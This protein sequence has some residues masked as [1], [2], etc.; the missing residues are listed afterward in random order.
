TD[1]NAALSVAMTNYAQA[2]QAQVAP[3]TQ[4]A[5]MSATSL[6]QQTAQLS[7][8]LSNVNTSHAPVGGVTA[9]QSFS[10]T[11]KSID[12]TSFSLGSFT[13]GQSSSPTASTP[14]SSMSVSDQYSQAAFGTALGRLSSIK[15]NTQSQ[16]TAITKGVGYLTDT[17]LAQVA[18]METQIAAIDARTTAMVSPTIT[19][20][21]VAA[22]AEQKAVEIA[23]IAETVATQEELGQATMASNNV[24]SIQSRI[25]AFDSRISAAKADTTV[26]QT[27]VTNNSKLAAYDVEVA[28]GNVPAPTSNMTAPAS[29]A[30]ADIGI[31]LGLNP[32]TANAIAANVNSF[33]NAV[34]GV[35]PGLATVSAVTNYTETKALSKEVA[36]Q[37]QEVV[38]ALTAAGVANPYSFLSQDEKNQLSSANTLSSQAK[39]LGSQAIGIAMMDIMGISTIGMANSL[40]KSAAQSVVS[41][42]TTTASPVSKS[43]T[44]TDVVSNATPNNVSISYNTSTNTFTVSTP[45]S[46]AGRV[47]QGRFSTTGQA[48]TSSVGYRS[49]TTENPASQAVTANKSAATSPSTA[50]NTTATGRST[51]VG[52][53]SA[54][55]ENPASQ[56][57]AAADNV[58]ATPN[59]VTNTPAAGRTAV[60]AE[61]PA[62]KAVAASDNPATPRSLADNVSTPAS[63]VDNSAVPGVTRSNDSFL[64][65]TFTSRENPASRNIT[66]TV[67]A[68]AELTSAALSPTSITSKSIAGVADRVASAITRSADDIATTP[69]QST[70]SVT[71]RST[72]NVTPTNQVSVTP[73]SATKAPVATTPAV[74]LATLSGVPSASIPSSQTP[75]A[76]TETPT[77]QAV[78]TQAEATPPATTE[79]PTTATQGALAEAGIF[80]DNEASPATPTE[81]PSTPAATTPSSQAPTPPAD[82]PSSPTNAQP[83]A[84]N[85]TA[86]TSPSRDSVADTLSKIA[87]GVGSALGELLGV[88][89]AASK[90]TQTVN[91]ANLEN[92]PA[93]RDFVGVVPDSS[94]RFLEFSDNTTA[95][96]AL[97]RDL[98]NKISDLSDAGTT[99]TLNTII[100]KY[101]PASDS[102]NPTQHA[103]NIAR[104]VAND[105]PDFTANTPITVTDL[106]GPVGVGL[107]KGF[108]QAEEGINLPTAEAAKGVAAYTA[109]PSVPTTLK[110]GVYAP[111]NPANQAQLDAI[112]SNPSVATAEVSP[113]QATPAPQIV[114]DLTQIVRGAAELSPTVIAVRAAASFFDRALTP[115]AKQTTPAVQAPTNAVATPAVL[116]STPTTAVS[117][118]TPGTNVRQGLITSQVDANG[119]AIDTKGVDPRLVDIIAETAKDFPL[120]VELFSGKVG[121]SKGTHSRGLAVDIMIYDTAGNPLAAYMVSETANIYALFAERARKV[122]MK[123]YPELNNSFV[124]G[125]AFTGMVKSPGG[126]AKYGG[127][128]FMDFRIG[129]AINTNQMQAYKFGE[130]WQEGFEYYTAGDVLGIGPRAI[131]EADYAQLEGFQLSPAQVASQIEKS[132]KGAKQGGRSTPTQFHAGLLGH[133]SIG[134]Q[135]TISVE[136]VPVEVTPVEVV[137]VEV[138]PVLASPSTQ[139]STAAPSTVAQ[140]NAPTLSSSQTNQPSVPAVTT[141][142]IPSQSNPTSNTP[143]PGGNSGTPPNNLGVTGPGIGSAPSSISAIEKTSLAV[144]STVAAVVAFVASVMGDDEESEN[145]EENQTADNTTTPP[146]QTSETPVGPTS[147]AENT[148]TSVPPNQIQSTNVN[149]NNYVIND[150]RDSF[151]TSSKPTT[152][153]LIQVDGNTGDMYFSVEGVYTDN[154]YKNYNY[155]HEED[156]PNE[157]E[158]ETENPSII[159]DDQRQNVIYSDGT[160]APVVVDGVWYESVEDSNYVYTVEY[161]QDGELVETAENAGV[162]P[163]GN[164]LSNLLNSLFSDTSSYQLADIDAVTRALIDPDSEVPADEYYIY[165]V[166]LKNGD[167]R[168]TTVPKYT[169]YRYMNERF[170]ET[171][172]VGNVLTLIAES[173][174]IPPPSSGPVMSKIVETL[175]D[176]GLSALDLFRNNEGDD[177]PIVTDFGTLTPSDDDE[178][179]MNDIQS[180]LV[181]LDVEAECPFVPGLTRPYLYEIV[182]A[183]NAI[184]GA[185]SDQAFR[186]VRCGGGEKQDFVDQIADHFETFDDV[187]TLDRQR[188]SEMIRFSAF[189]DLDMSSLVAE[190]TVETETVST[191]TTTVPENT[192]TETETFKPNVSNEI[193]FEVKAIDTQGQTV[194]DWTNNSSIN[195]SSGSQLYFRWDGSSYQQCLPFLNDNGN[196]SLTV[197]NRAMTTGNTESEG[198]NITERSAVYRIECGGQRNNEFGVDDRS[199]EITV[200]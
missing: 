136:V 62:S 196:Y 129:G 56:A 148:V 188:L 32:T 179:T 111:T 116:T 20:Q 64:G 54:T 160:Y 187:G 49:V 119:V 113:Q 141:A 145:E 18:A 38:S 189:Q 170:A 181:L 85:Q 57:V 161:Y 131:T 193:T 142:S 122:Q 74:G 157:I 197:K 42:R 174:E 94:G 39:A 23:S 130:G 83:A 11:N 138:V 98:D 17:Q 198:Y 22:L 107:I 158:T 100:P 183:Q 37:A 10:T 180:V 109:I 175:K 19:N 195:I 91:F 93:T 125:G 30:I 140:P 103:N 34:V 63:A 163:Q 101:S 182:I 110:N 155:I 36:V 97:L 92:T 171:G 40:G 123:L 71:T 104:V 58:P 176:V 7:T 33:M 114:Q 88:K 184:R 115:E 48:N 167:V 172:F 177:N 124:W 24:M 80:A 128:D 149:Q 126:T 65:R 106:Q 31:S 41:G 199:I 4:S 108:A 70:V 15:S 96:R 112:R 194:L 61:N 73:A 166:Y 117:P 146:T 192:T 133:R 78:A 159:L 21:A 95:G 185:T 105:V 190:A 151:S 144:Y 127:G 89:P 153:V 200:E 50:A 27:E 86:P 132:T 14:N 165:R 99:P 173:V 52:R 139:P 152:N 169:S 79:T 118:G 47:A 87:D 59:T 6:S 147:G 35:V 162:L 12:A 121:R 29:S 43:I 51:P 150:D 75:T 46:V 191:S 44:P 66:A 137:P 168:G 186:A 134:P 16:I 135:Q 2:K 13:T 69:T 67:M 143:L 55:T 5:L 154:A 84:P 156:D 76:Q 77:T 53:N 81:T 82:I 45:P 28:L 1:V 26:A 3:P 72:T 178:I 60:S 120:R 25:D 164:P 8:N 68:L 9:T 90:P 102:N